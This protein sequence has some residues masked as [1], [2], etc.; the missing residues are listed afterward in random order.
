MLEP[1]I[2]DTRMMVFN[3]DARFPEVGIKLLESRETHPAISMII[4]RLEPGGVIATHDHPIE[5]ETAYILSGT[6]TLRAGDRDYL[7]EAGMMVTIPP[8]LAHSMTNHGELPLE[9]LALHSPATR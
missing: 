3:R 7:L 2:L 9:I 8:R 4:A 1:R 5:T 6:G